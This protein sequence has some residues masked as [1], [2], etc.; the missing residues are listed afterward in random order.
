MSA[1][2]FPIQPAASQPPRLQPERAFG[3]LAGL[4]EAIEGL[5]WQIVTRAGDDSAADPCFPHESYG[6]YTERLDALRL[7]HTEA[8]RMAEDT[9]A[10][11]LGMLW[12]GI[13]NGIRWGVTMAIA[14]VAAKGGRS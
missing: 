9:D 8:S 13:S 5:Y 12:D 7:T 11:A 10:E 1:S 6:R 2:N 14:M 3:E 4:A